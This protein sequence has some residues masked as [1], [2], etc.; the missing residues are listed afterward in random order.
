MKM[1]GILLCLVAAMTGLSNCMLHLQVCTSN[2]PVTLVVSKLSVIQKLQLI[3]DAPMR[4]QP[5]F[6]RHT[7]SSTILYYL[8]SNI[9][10][11]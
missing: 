3:S 5:F 10:Q 8:F 7:H 1:V 4:M 9:P 6:S 11:E 2:A